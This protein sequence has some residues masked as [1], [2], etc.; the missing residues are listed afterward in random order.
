MAQQMEKL[1]QISY[2]EANSIVEETSGQKKITAA[3]AK[4]FGSVKNMADEL[5]GLSKTQ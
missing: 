5:Y 3:T 4:T 1:V 2:S